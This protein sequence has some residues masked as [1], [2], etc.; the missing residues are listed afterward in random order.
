[1]PSLQQ[2]MHGILRTWGHNVYLQRYSNGAFSKTLEKHTVRHMYPNVRGLPQALEE[3]REG[4][5]HTVDMIYYFAADAR[6]NEGDRIYESDP[7]LP[8]EQSTLLID[9]A[10]PMRGKGG[11]VVYYTVGATRE[12]PS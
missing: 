3:R 4:I 6:P 9:Y 7:R 10:V 12:E 5:V 1:M 8:N 2:V 11:I